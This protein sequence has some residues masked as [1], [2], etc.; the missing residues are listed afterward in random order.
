M[1]VSCF[2][3]CF[4]YWRNNESL[5][6]LHNS[7]KLEVALGVADRVPFVSLLLWLLCNVLGVALYLLESPVQY[8]P[9]ELRVCAPI[10]LQLSL[11]RSRSAIDNVHNGPRESSDF[12]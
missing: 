8:R 5:Y 6:V 9:V 11:A 10:T 1:F 4:P 2:L 3:V 7:G 12:L